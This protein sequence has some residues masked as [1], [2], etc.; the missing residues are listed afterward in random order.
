MGRLDDRVAF[1]TGAA[2]GIG[3]ACAQRMAEEGARIA[4]FD[5]AQPDPAAWKRVA[6]A[7]PDESFQIG[8][9]RDESAV[10]GAIAATVDRF[11]RL[12]I[13][14]NNAGTAGG[15]PVHMID[16]AEW[17]RVID[18]NLKGT[19][20]CSKYAITQM[21]EQSGGGNVINIASVEGIEGFEG[22]SAYN[23]SKGGV[24]LLTR[25]QAIDY[26]RRGIRVN[27]VCPG[28]IETPLMA[29]TF[30]E[31]LKGPLERVVEA[32]QLGRMGRPE[33]IADAVVFLASDEASYITGQTLVVDGGYTCGH[34]VGISKLIGLE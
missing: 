29:S 15:G 33:E 3:A 24:V 13:L 5:L 17:D 27:A 19:F 34:R 31:S 18:V 26:G 1:I 25:N 6:E 21:L 11:G 20:L 16:S 7:A 2:S 23:A 32:T 4:G 9:V 30:V 28:F 14:V 22:G 12:D 10:S 8:D